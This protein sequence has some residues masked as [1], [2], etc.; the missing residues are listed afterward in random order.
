MVRIIEYVAL[1]QAIGLLQVAQAPV[2]PI[3]TDLDYQNFEHIRAI[4]I[5]HLS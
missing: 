2:N 5:P 1:S 4:M 3:Y